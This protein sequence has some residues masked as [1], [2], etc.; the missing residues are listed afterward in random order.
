MHV[1]AGIKPEQSVPLKYSSAVNFLAL[2]RPFQYFVFTGFTL[3]G[4]LL[5]GTNILCVPCDMTTGVI[6]HP[7]GFVQ[8]LASDD[9]CLTS[10]DDCDR[11]GNDWTTEYRFFTFIY[12]FPWHRYFCNQTFYLRM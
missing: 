6:D 5:I 12:C 11:T 7:N 8:T 9:N 3:F 10:G 2:P 1:K 4:I